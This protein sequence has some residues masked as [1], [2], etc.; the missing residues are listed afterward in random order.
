MQQQTFD[1]YN[2]IPMATQKTSIILM[3]DVTTQKNFLK[4]KTVL[5]IVILFDHSEIVNRTFSVKKNKKIRS[6]S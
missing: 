2:N 6:N 1:A 5:F 4:Q 3:Y